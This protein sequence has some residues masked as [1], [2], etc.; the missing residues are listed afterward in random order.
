MKHL[1]YLFLILTF[2]I[3]CKK[4]VPLT[5]MSQKDKIETNTVT[6]YIDKWK[7]TYNLK[8]ES[9]VHMNET[10]NLNYIFKIKND[11]IIIVQLDDNPKEKTNCEILKVSKDT[12]FFQEKNSSQKSEYKLYKNQQRDYIIGG[13]SIYMINPPNGSYSVTKE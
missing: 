4:Q 13:H 7:G 3:S 11:P 5:V 9:L 6:P 8:L 10:H 1:S 2:F 12:L